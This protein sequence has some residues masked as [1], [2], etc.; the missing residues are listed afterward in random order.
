MVFEQLLR[1]ALEA[2][3]NFSLYLEEQENVPFM[4]SAFEIDG[5]NTKSFKDLCV[6]LVDQVK[7][8]S[9]AFMHTHQQMLDGIEQNEELQV[10]L[11][12]NKAQI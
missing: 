11:K 9:E 4:M 10:K 8:L 3:S 2:Q 1:Q 12:N 6:R 7:A 5:Y